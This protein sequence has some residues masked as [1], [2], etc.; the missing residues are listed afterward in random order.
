MTTPRALR[1]RR[2]D[3]WRARL[4]VVWPRLRRVASLAFFVLV[5]ALLVHHARAIEWPAVGTALRDMPP[6]RLAAAAGIAAA[7][8]L[9]YSCFDLLGRHVS[10]HRLPVGRT[11]AINFVSYAFNLNFGSL[12]GGVA[13]RFRLYHRQGLDNTTITE[14]VSLSMLT[15]W[16][17]YMALA[18]V[19]FAWQPLALPPDWNID[20][21][22]LRLLGLVL[23]GLAAAWIGGC[24][25]LGQRRLTLRGR[26]LRMPG[27]RLALLQMAMSCTNWALIGS[28]VYLLLHGG[29]ELEFPAVL[30]V[31][32]VAAV[33][34]VLAHVPAGLGVLEAVFVALLGHRMPQPELLASLLCYRVVYYLLPLAAAVALYFGLEARSAATAAARRN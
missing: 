9:L 7:S 18:G 16:L 28:A 14:V 25:V 12:V 32:L 30:S 6:W 3:S 19:L 24:A 23:L 17:G 22:G 34:G 11:M 10:G 26:V 13:M 8:H 2:A 21:T 31:L 1:W 4:P 27:L 5:A 20:S 29:P 33:A 15:N